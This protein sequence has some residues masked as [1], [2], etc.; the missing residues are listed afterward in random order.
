MPPPPLPP[1]PSSPFPS[2]VPCV[3]FFWLVEGKKVVWWKRRRVAG[4]GVVLSSGGEVVRGWGGR[5]VEEDVVKGGVGRCLQVA[6]SACLMVK[7]YDAFRTG[8]PGR[9]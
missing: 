7:G 8:G 9:K 3:P 1:Q 6:L 5:L 2:T 4:R